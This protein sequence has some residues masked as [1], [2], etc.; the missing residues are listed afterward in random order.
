MG[1][2]TEKHADVV[3]GILARYPDKRSAVLLLM[4][5]AQD[6]YGYMSQEAM[7]EVAEILALDPT[8]V[9]SLAGFYSLY[10]EAPVGRY[11]LEICTD[12]ACAL[13]GADE[14]ADMAC[15]KLGVPPDVTTADGLFTVKKVMCLGAC[16]KAPMLQ[17]NLKF[18]ES[19]DEAKFEALLERLR[20]EAASGQEAPSVVQK[21]TGFARS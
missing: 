17:C 4:H 18:E 13:C 10:Y 15:Q 1:R 11:V 19:L 5:L 21:I 12:L 2:L 9:M 20:A 6:E 16:D 8:H 7:T 14:F 3:A